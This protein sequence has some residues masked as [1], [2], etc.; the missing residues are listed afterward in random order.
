MLTLASILAGALIGAAVGTVYNAS[1]RW[2]IHMIAI[3]GALSI[4]GMIVW[5]GLPVS[6][7]AFGA[8]SARLVLFYRV[9]RSGINSRDSSR[10]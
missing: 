2:L 9:D 10:E 6:G 8:L 5:A 1:D 7:F 3:V 4:L